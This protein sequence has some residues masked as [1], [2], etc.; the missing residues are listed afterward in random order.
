MTSDQRLFEIACSFPALRRKGVA[1][2]D[3]PGITPDD[4]FDLDLANYLYHGP[5]GGLS[6]GEFMILEA[7]LNFCNPDLH[8]RFNL[9][10]ALRILDPKNMQA[11]LIA[12]IRTYNRK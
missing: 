9:G 8:A 3:I 1:Q 11:L 7:L 12:I 5:G 6:N 4:F 10:Q 2:G